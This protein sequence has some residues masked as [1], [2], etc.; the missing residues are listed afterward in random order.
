[1]MAFRICV[2]MLL[3]GLSTSVVMSQGQ[4]S[5]NTGVPRPAPTGRPQIPSVQRSE[6]PRQ[7][8]PQPARADAAATAPKQGVVPVSGVEAPP[9][10]PP[11]S[12]LDPQLLQVLTEWADS[13][14]KIK[15]LRGTHVRY[16]FDEVFS[17][18]KRSKG[19]FYYVE[20]DKG[21]IDL[22][23]LK[24]GASDKPRKAGFTVQPESPERWICDGYKIYMINDA[25]K[26]YDVFELP[27]ELRGENIINGPLP[28]L[29]GMSPEFAH[30]RF[31]LKLLKD[32]P[33]EA[34]I[35]ALPRLK[36]DQANYKEARIILN[37]AIYMPRAVRLLD[38]AETRVTE[39]WFDDLEPNGAGV[40]AAVRKLMG[41]DPFHP[42]L[43]S[44]K[45]A[46]TA[47]GTASGSSVTPAGGRPAPRNAKVPTEGTGRARLE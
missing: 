40:K 36:S 45:V 9:Q 25:S 14:A 23:P 46:Q 26:E 15:E 8:R 41:E 17:T 47:A 44:Y 1:M 34:T 19:N 2:A 32:T 43:S 20:P 6:Q 18:E 10:I 27:L 35:L 31:E 3:S 12:S 30:R 7:Q 11:L 28:F 16:V 24:I 33:K 21:R 39:Y 5:R 13:S 29:F 37:K 42:N 22:E 38:P 4:P